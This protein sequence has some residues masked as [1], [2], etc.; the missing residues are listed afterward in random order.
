MITLHHTALDPIN[1]L[2]FDVINEWPPYSLYAEYFCTAII[3][4]N[5]EIRSLVRMK[6]AKVDS[7]Y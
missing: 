5:D 6:R 4:N 3:I 1:F 7:F 2:L